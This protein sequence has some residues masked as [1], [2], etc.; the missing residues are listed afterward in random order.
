MN[1]RALLAQIVTER[2]VLL[3]PTMMTWFTLAQACC[4]VPLAFGCGCFLGF[5]AA[6]GGRPTLQELAENL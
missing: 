4:I 6:K 5:S 2:G 3:T 1:P